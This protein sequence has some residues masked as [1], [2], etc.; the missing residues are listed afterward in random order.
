MRA[1][2]LLAGLAL[3]VLIVAKSAQPITASAAPDPNIAYTA[4][5]ADG[6][7][8][9]IN[10]RKV[11]LRENCYGCH[12]GRAG[13]GMCPSLRDGADVEDVIFDGTRS[14]MPSF[15]GR[16]TDREVQ[17]LQAY[18]DSLRSAQEPTFTHW[19]EPG[20]PTQ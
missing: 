5:S 7:G 20:T 2:S 6:D 17:D 19:W 13:G 3:V 11:F 1:V 16:V 18:I 12:G 15:R 10:G 4:S 14:G 9:R 8:D